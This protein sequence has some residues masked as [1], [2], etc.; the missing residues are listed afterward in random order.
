MDTVAQDLL[1]FNILKFTKRPCLG[2]WY[3]E[4]SLYNDADLIG[5]FF[6]GTN[7]TIG[8][9]FAKAK[10]QEEYKFLCYHQTYSYFLDIMKHDIGTR[11]HLLKPENNYIMVEDGN[12][13][14]F[15]NILNDIRKKNITDV[16]RRKVKNFSYIVPKDRVIYKRAHG[17]T[18]YRENKY[19]NYAYLAICYLSFAIETSKNNKKYNTRNF[20]VFKKDIIEKAFVIIKKS[21][22]K[23]LIKDLNKIIIDYVASGDDIIY[24]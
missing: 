21:L 11:V 24:I 13:Y 19:I 15:E 1:E 12:A 5:K 22:K 4:F 17:A 2:Y 7:N 14:I 9:N 16:M 18:A 3:Y 20:I 23:V 6:S 8:I 10:L